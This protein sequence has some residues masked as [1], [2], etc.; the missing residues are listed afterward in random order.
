[1][2]RFFAKRAGRPFRLVPYFF[3]LSLLLMGCATALMA[4]YLRHYSA[5]Q[6]LKLE[7]SRAASLVEMFENSLWNDFRPLLPLANDANRLQQHARQ[8]Q[9]RERVIRLM[10]DTGVIKLKVY[11]L[12]GRTLFSTD[13]VQI[14]EDE[15]DN[16]GFQSAAAGAPA[17]ELAHSHSIDA[18]ERTLTERDIISTYVPVHGPGGK[19]EGVLEIYLDATPFIVDTDAQLRWLTLAICALMIVLFVAQMLVVR[20]AGRIIDKQ[21]RSLEDANQE[22]DQRVSERTRELSEANARLEDEVIERRRAEET[23]DRLAHHDPLTGLPNRLMFQQQ[24]AEALSR[25]AQRPHG[26]ALLFIDLDR[27]KDVNDT[28]GHY[29]GDQLLTSVAARFSAHVRPADLLAR[30]GGDEFICL[31]D[32]LAS[33]DDASSVANKLL[34]LFEQ[35]FLLNGNEIYLSASV[36]ISFAA[37]DGMDADTLLRAADLAMYQAKADGRNR[38]LCYTPHMSAAVAERVAIENQLRQAIER[39]EIEVHYQAKVDSASG[40]VIGAEALARWTSPTLGPVSP[41]RFIP[42]AEENGLILPLGA[43]VLEQACAQLADWQR[44]GFALPALSVNLS[45]RQLAQAD[46]PILVGE[47]LRKHELQPAMLELEITESV[48]MAADNAVAALNALRRLGLKLSIDDFGTGYSSLAYLRNLPVQTLKI[49]RSFVQDIGAGGEAI[50][51]TIISLANS[52][53]LDT[54]AEGVE[55]RGQVDFLAS[56][57]CVAIQGY[58][59]SR[60]K[61]APAFLE[62]WQ[63]RAANMLT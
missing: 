49:D 1:M 58:Y 24:L 38:C 33:R 14:G 6:L 53:H 2:R 45:V 34:A 61:A 43:L 44:A 55:T 8:A 62:D 9:L 21:A 4:G 46:L 22:L 47:L 48:I 23:L 13:A 28:L 7:K 32:K 15:S 41:A 3:L 36:G 54:V 30:L 31:L 17:S 50:I 35:P 12:N 51:Q 42:L 26:L 39:R 60:P 29:A 37:Q 11:A 63:N 10:R 57:G 18:F 20:H 19:P 59:Y 27:F 56:A 5:E 16:E 40:L 52:L 25:A